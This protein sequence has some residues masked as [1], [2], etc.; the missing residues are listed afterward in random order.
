[1]TINSSELRKKSFG[2]SRRLVLS[3]VLLLLLSFSIAVF[4]MW[5]LKDFYN[6]FATFRG[7]STNVNLV[8]KIDKDMAELQRLILVF[9]HAE[10]STTTK[11]I[12]ELH[13]TLKTS[14]SQLS[15]TASFQEGL[16]KERIAQMQIG[17]ENFGEKIADIQSQY[18][19]REQ[20]INEE[21]AASS[22]RMQMEMKALMSRPE[23]L[24]N[25]V[26]RDHLWNAKIKLISAQAA[27]ANYFSKHVIEFRQ[28]VERELTDALSELQQ[29]KKRST[30]AGLANQL[31]QILNSAA[32]VKVLF[33][34]SVQADRN[35]LFLVNVVIPGDMGELAILAEQLK[36]ESLLKQEKLFANT[37]KSIEFNEYFL[38]TLSIVGAAITMGFA[39]WTARRISEPIVS[40]TTTFNQ[41]AKGDSLSDIPGMTRTDEIGQLAQSANVFR[42]MNVRTQE[43]LEQAEVTSKELAQREQLLEQAIVK[44]EEANLAK[45][46]FLAAMSH[47]IRTPMAGVIGMSELL[48]NTELS[49]QQLDWATT[50]KSS[51]QNLL[52]ILNEILDQSKLE[53]GML[54]IDVIDVHLHSM[55]EDVVLLFGPKVEEKGIRL[56]L[57]VDGRLPV[58]I[59]AD[60]LRVGQILSNFLSNALKF[61][62]SGTITVKVVLDESESDFPYIRFSVTDSG[63][64]LSKETAAR[65]FSAFV[66]ADSST[67]RTYGGTGLGLSIS[68]QLAQLLGGQIG[69]DSLEGSGSTFWF[70]IPMVKAETEVAARNKTQ[71]SDR[72]IASRQLSVLVAE[73]NEV[74]Q[75]LI[76]TILEA[77]GHEVRIAENGLIATEVVTQHH[78]DLVLMDIRMPV[79]DGVQAT[80]HIRA[81]STAIAHIP[82][83][84]LTADIT[85]GNIKEY[86]DAGVNDICSKPLVLPQLLKAIDKL[87]GAEI[88]TMVP[89]IHPVLKQ[90]EMVQEAMA[91]DGG[92]DREKDEVTVDFAEVLRRAHAIVNQQADQQADRVD[93]H[94]K[95]AFQI[96]GVPEDK[97]AQMLLNYETNLK[98]KLSELN[99]LLKQLID[100]PHNEEL[101]SKTKLLTHTLKGNGT[102][103]GYHLVTSIAT[104]ADNF[105]KKTEVLGELEMM[106]LSR[107]VAA[108]FFIAEKRLAGDGGEAG[109][110]L[111]QTLNN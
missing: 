109:R 92:F 108:L 48:I 73:D 105:L 49:P 45:S 103:F 88:H 72:W 31:E 5:G 2:I 64:G 93:L 33:L 23:V 44:A 6:R 81:M 38:W 102:I 8:L 86:M 83:I 53:A 28:Q 14:I 17:I 12:A 110:L 24:S 70:T 107:Y 54:V 52:S 19:F 99:D 60:P 98:S 67:S 97:L 34:Q 89:S 100:D 37:Q 79:L 111:L 26:M 56:S 84:A 16:Q 35:Y 87:M 10:K 59:K 47:E 85:T 32:T 74:N 27:S 77:L 91:L 78:F 63:I 30:Q 71:S 66:Q 39:L 22:I 18:E 51:G 57:E 29:A 42:Q 101:K 3:F 82:I 41:L 15:T 13:A 9:T 25:Y 4:N 36:T 68:K 95:S 55:V 11:Q 40:I 80:Q 94:P 106:Q 65:L 1:M 61:T 75:E 7:E 21:L 46:R 58:G 50:I 62:Q 69:V 76:T 104:D 20:A 43:L 96:P 90:D